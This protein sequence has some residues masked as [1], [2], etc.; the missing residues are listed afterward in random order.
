M[1]PALASSRDTELLKLVNDLIAAS[2][3]NEKPKQKIMTEERSD[4]IVQPP[5][6]SYETPL[7][8]SRVPCTRTL[9]GDQIESR[10]LSSVVVECLELLSRHG[11][12]C[13]DFD[14]SIIVYLLQ[15]IVDIS[16]EDERRS[17]LLGYLPISAE[18]LDNIEQEIL[19]FAR[20][21]VEGTLG[22]KETKKII[23]LSDLSL[24]KADS[25]RSSSSGNFSEVV[26]S[27]ICDLRSS[28]KESFE[29]LR[30]LFHAV[31]VD[32]VLFVFRNECEEDELRTIEMLIELKDNEEWMQQILAKKT[33]CEKKYFFLIY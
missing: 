3:E 23:P 25:H 24:S 30:E 15:S 18:Q 22:A 5:I 9:G 7:V 14:E 12:D 27:I 2:R 17:L 13:G 10:S 8:E 1:F 20:S 11:I 21:Y 33:A 28:A 16:D 19:Q 29:S 31:P 32:L 26:E 4:S 6:I